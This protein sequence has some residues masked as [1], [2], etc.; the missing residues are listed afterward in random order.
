MIC[1]EIASITLTEI[2]NMRSSGEGV[3]IIDVEI[4]RE[5]F[6]RMDCDEDNYLG[7]ITDKNKIHGRRNV[8]IWI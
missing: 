7:C 5:R 6:R 2:H 8:R 1:E 3:V 4:M